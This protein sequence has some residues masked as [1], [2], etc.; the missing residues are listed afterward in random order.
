MPA[1]L[2]ISD[3]SIPVGHELIVDRFS[4][5]VPGGAFAALLGPN[6]AG[7]TTLLGGLSGYLPIAA[8][9]VTLNGTLLATLTPRQRARQVALVPQVSRQDLPLTVREAVALARY[10]HMRANFSPA[11]IINGTV[12]AAL[13]S[14]GLSELAERRVGSLSGGELRRMLLA[15]GL[16]QETPLLLLDE[17]TAFLDPPARRMIMDEMRRV[18]RERELTVLAALHDIDLAREFADYILL[19]KDGRLL[20]GGE[21]AA[22]LTPDNL[23]GL[24]GCDPRWL[25]EIEVKQ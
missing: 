7:K 12:A 23:A 22:I 20:A 4:A 9:E 2:I 13:E 3:L 10:P 24:Y 17:P 25:G 19:I 21:P 8:G 5:R 11:G 14:L 6:G 18:A 16:V 15:Q 1:E